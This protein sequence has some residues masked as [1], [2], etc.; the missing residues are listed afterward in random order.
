MWCEVVGDNHSPAL[1]CVWQWDIVM[2]DRHLV[3]LE[4]AALV[5]CVDSMCV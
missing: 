5:M 2:F 4:L 1:I 3:L